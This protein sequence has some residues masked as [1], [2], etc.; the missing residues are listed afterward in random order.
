V[1]CSEEKFL[2]DKVIHFYEGLRLLL[3]AYFPYEIT[4]LFVCVCVSPIVTRQWLDKYPPII[5]RQQL[6]RNVT[7]VT[8]TH[9]TIEEL[10]DASFLIGPCR[11]KG[12]TLLVLPRTSCLNSRSISL[13][14]KLRNKL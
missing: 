13:N 6:G 11:I 9:T 2:R 7:V 3:L 4:L 12:S 5:A 1:A 14:E 10:L 8:N